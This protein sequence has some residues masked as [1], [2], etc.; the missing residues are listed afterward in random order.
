[1]HTKI[2]INRDKKGRGC[3]HSSH[4]QNKCSREF[5]RGCGGCAAISRRRVDRSDER[6]VSAERR[7]VMTRGNE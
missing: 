5:D 2:K 4:I 6:K 3:L 1:M 7:S